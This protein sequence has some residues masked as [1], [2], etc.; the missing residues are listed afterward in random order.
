M[1]GLLLACDLCAIWTGSDWIGWVSHSAAFLLDALKENKPEHAADP[2][3]FG[4]IL[5]LALLTTGSLLM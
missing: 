3:V 2:C 4:G 5:P 1:L